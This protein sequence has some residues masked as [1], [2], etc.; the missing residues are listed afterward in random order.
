LKQ[1]KNIV[2]VFLQATPVATDITVLEKQIKDIENVDSVHHLHVWSM[3]G[4]HVVLTVHVVPE[5]ALTPDEYAALKKNFRKIVEEHGM[6]HSTLEIE[7]PDE[8]CRVEDNELC[9]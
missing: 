7:W 8:S 9:K 6:Y 1:L 2:P 3:D 5:T 4:K